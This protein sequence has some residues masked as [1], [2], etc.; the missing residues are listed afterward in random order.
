MSKFWQKI[1]KFYYFHLANPI[2][3]K[4]EG[5]GFKYVVRRFW[6]DIET[7]SG[8]WKM[9]VTASEHPFGYLVAGLT[10]KSEENLFGFAEIMYY[11]NA[12]LTRDQVLVDDVQKAMREYEARLAKTPLEPEDEERAA[13]EEVKAVQEYVDASPKER[14]KMERETNKRFKKA[15]A[16]SLQG[17]K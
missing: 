15:V 11:L 10:Q 1:Q 9:R 6:L 3:Q 12:T 8:N 4:G 7:L 14:K 17:E 2:V 5:H 16:Q 13:I